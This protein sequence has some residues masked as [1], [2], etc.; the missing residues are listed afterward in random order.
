MST[1]TIAKPGIYEL[2]EQVYHADPC[3]YPSASSSFLKVMLSETPRHAWEAHPRLNPDHES[4]EGEEK[5]DRGH[6][7]HQLMLGGI[8]RFC[9]IDEDS[10]RSNS[11][12]AKRAKAYVDGLIPIL[13]HR[14]PEV[15]AMCDAGK[16][17]IDR[18]AYENERLIFTGGQPEQTIVWTEEIYGI[19]I[20]C[21]AKLDY[22]KGAGEIF[23]DYKSL[24]ASIHPDRLHKYAENADWAFQ[25]AFYERGIQKVIGDDM[26]DFRFVVHEA[27]KPHR[28][29]IVKSN[30]TT[31]AIAHQKVEF[32]LHQ[33]AWCM[34]EN[35][36]P[37]FPNTTVVLGVSPWANE[38]FLA[39]QHA[40]KE[41]GL[42]EYFDDMKAWQAPLESV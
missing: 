33:F 13:K 28:L 4:S 7:C 22:F 1:I 41:R 29:L 18:M 3:A 19:L 8:D 12:K 9:V 11:A 20:Y 14:L 42:R 21:R 35:S 38:Q 36:W 24:D 10:Y 6:A 25:Q 34:K 27:S 37:G 40:A 15:I 17:Q 23:P 30:P 16:A 32:A 5:F 31:L 26:P 2:P 39:M